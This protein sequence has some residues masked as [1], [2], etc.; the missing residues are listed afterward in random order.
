MI[1]GITERQLEWWAKPSCRHCHGRG[2]I[3]FVKVVDDFFDES[4]N[5]EVPK[6]CDC[7]RRRMEK[8][9]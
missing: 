2:T 1:D 9:S 5:V 3:I 6:V 7:V 8:R 4:K